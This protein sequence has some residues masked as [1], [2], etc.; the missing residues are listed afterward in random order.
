MLS[1]KRILVIGGAGF[2]GS[3]L[4]EHL[5]K[6]NAVVSIDNYS[7]GQKNNHVDGVEYRVG[8]AKDITMIAGDDSFDIVFHFGEYSRVESSLFEIEKVL[9]MTP[10]KEAWYWESEFLKKVP[11]DVRK[12]IDFE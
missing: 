2:I 8:D 9:E 3:N 5:V 7:T 4:V 11:E 10:S 12:N 1:N 6:Q